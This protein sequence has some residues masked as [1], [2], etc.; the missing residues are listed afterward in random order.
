MLLFACLFILG[1]ALAVLSPYPPVRTDK[2]KMRVTQQRLDVLIRELDALPP[3]PG[4]IA[5]PAHKSDGCSTSDGDVFQPSAGRTWTVMTNAQTWAAEQ[6]VVASLVD[7]GWVKSPDRGLIDWFSLTLT[8][9]GWQA[10]ATV[11]RTSE[12]DMVV[13]DPAVLVTM[14][15]T[16]DE[17]CT[18]G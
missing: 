12:S 18:Q 14:R 7:S 9:D 1:S 11:Y 4:S 15:V 5:E 8:R 2:E 17:P 13:R 6:A 3:P 10:I 16:T